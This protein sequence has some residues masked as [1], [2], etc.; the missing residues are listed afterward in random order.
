MTPETTRRLCVVAALALVAGAC[1]TS[2]ARPGKGG[3]ERGV[4]SW[5]GPEFHGRRT[6]NGERYDM[7]AMTAAHRTLPFG[8]ILEV[9]NLDNGRRARVRINDR[10]PFKKNRILDLSHQAAEELGIVGPGTAEVEI[11]PVGLL[12]R[13]Y[14]VQVGAFQDSGAAQD[15][16]D[17]LCRDYQGVRLRSD[18]VWHRVQVGEFEDRDA[19]D[20][21][22]RELATQGYSALVIP[23]DDDA[24]R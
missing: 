4:A 24:P 11:R 21:L 17:R 10:G 15:L 23:L 3:V 2:R 6:A 22:R 9:R 8:T 14:A 18:S 19:A 20:D 16:V 7:N 5:Y 1:A 12:A 13:R